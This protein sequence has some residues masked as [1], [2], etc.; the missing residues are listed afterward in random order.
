MKNTKSNKHFGKQE[1]ANQS[2]YDQVTDAW[3]IIFGDNFHW[4]YFEAEDTDLNQVGDALTD[5]LAEL[6]LFTKKSNVLDVGCGIGGPALYLHKKFGCYVT[7]ISTSEKGLK[8]AANSCISKGYAK[9]VCFKFANALENGFPNNFFDI[10]WMMESS[11]L[12]SDKKRVFEENFRVL[13]KGGV[14]LLADIMV[15]R[16]QTEKELLQNYKELLVLQ[17]VFGQM[18]HETLSFYQ[19][20]AQNVGFADIVM[21][22]IGQETYPSIYHYKERIKNNLFRI[23]EFLS[24][25][26]INKFLSV[27]DILDRLH[28]INLTTYG[29]MKAEKR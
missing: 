18:K 6:T 24:P 4:G 19:E 28:N 11:H 7:G 8:I 9:N 12:M 5:K 26:K 20:T 25:L 27:W 1:R 16:K 29:L 14:M 2:H 13:R 17:S 23:K 21:F 22:D 10:V 3:R 15:Q